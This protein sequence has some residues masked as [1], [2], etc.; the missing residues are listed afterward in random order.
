MIFFRKV[1]YHFIIDKVNYIDNNGNSSK[2]TLDFQ[3]KSENPLEIDQSM[4]RS[5][6]LINNNYNSIFNNQSQFSKSIIFSQPDNIDRKFPKNYLN[7]NSNYSNMENHVQ[8]SNKQQIPFSQS[9]LN[10][11]NTNN[12][13]LPNNPSN[14]QFLNSMKQLPGINNLPNNPSNQQFLNSNLQNNPS[15]QQFL[16]SNF[17]N[18]PSNLQGPRMNNLINN[19]S[20]QQILNSNLQGPRMN[21]LINNQSNP[22]QNINI[23][24]NIATN[25][26]FNNNMFK[27]Q[28]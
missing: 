7:N 13:N 22:Q 16:N 3:I 2:K 25:N 5:D 12:N 1:F 8:L 9:N 23:R 18:N 15:N 11:N 17:Q 26:K 28:K 19:Q 10:M 21:N 14:Q 24:A 4:K 27:H 20:N 6:E